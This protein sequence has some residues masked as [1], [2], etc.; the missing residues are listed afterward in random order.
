MRDAANILLAALIGAGAMAGWAEWSR[1]SVAKA[2]VSAR[3]APAGPPYTAVTWPD[4]VPGLVDCAIGTG[5]VVVCVHT[6]PPQLKPI[7]YPRPPAEP[8]V[9]EVKVKG[10]AAPVKKKPQAREWRDDPPPRKRGKRER[11]W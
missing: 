2:P 9:V 6:W 1:P 5:S 7:T 3:P 4:Y 11:Y 10:K 8:E